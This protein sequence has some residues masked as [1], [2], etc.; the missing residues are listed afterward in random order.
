MYL[1]YKLTFTD[2]VFKLCLELKNGRE[3]ATILANPYLKKLFSNFE[4]RY[5]RNHLLDSDQ[6]DIIR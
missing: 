5:L 3:Y 1:L 4:C 2:F 6:Q